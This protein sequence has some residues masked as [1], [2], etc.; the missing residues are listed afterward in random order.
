MNIE[1]KIK[2]ITKN[3]LRPCISP[4]GK[5]SIARGIHRDNDG[6]KDVR[7]SH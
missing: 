3:G 6:V 2:Q 4:D 1:N 7:H 5:W